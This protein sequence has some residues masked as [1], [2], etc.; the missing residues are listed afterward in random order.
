MPMARP[1]VIK[2]NDHQKL[3]FGHLIVSKMFNTVRACVCVRACACVCVCVCVCVS[4]SARAGVCVCVGGYLPRA[5][6]CEGPDRALP[7]GEQQ[8][9]HFPHFANGP[10]RQVNNKKIAIL[11]FA[12]KADTGGSAGPGPIGGGGPRR[13]AARMGGRAVMAWGLGWGGVGGGEGGGGGG[14]LVRGVAG[15]GRWP[16]F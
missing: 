16:I 15:H 5:A 11:G 3:R 9:P 4:A 7:A 8:D 14:G 1:Q 6:R 2:M 12:F 10:C 13:P